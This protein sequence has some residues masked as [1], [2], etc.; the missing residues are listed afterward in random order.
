MFGV[1][2]CE[3]LFQEPFAK[4]SAR[5]DEMVSG[6]ALASLAVQGAVQRRGNYQI[7]SETTS[8]IKPCVCTFIE[9]AQWEKHLYIIVVIILKLWY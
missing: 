4:L 3:L 6:R 2:S 5:I 9:P 1:A 8:P 7:P